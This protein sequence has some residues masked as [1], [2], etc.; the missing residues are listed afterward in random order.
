MKRHHFEASVCR[1]SDRH[2][3]EAFIQISDGND[4]IAS[5]TFDDC[6]NVTDTTNA[7]CAYF[8]THSPEVISSIV[9]N[10]NVLFEI[11]SAVFLCFELNRKIMDDHPEKIVA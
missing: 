7:M 8:L 5:I 11:H 3:W 4:L 2:L 1:E 9:K 6:A 10:C